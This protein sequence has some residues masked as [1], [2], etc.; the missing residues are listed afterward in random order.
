MIRRNIICKEHI[1]SILLIDV[2]DECSERV[3]VDQG[4][5]Q[6]RVGEFPLTAPII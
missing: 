2:G 5:E 4:F 1:V 6:R 3:A